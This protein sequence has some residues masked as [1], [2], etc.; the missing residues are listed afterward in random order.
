M[1]DI[2]ARSAANALHQCDADWTLVLQTSGAE[3]GIVSVKDPGNYGHN[4]LQN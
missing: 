1:F 4:F 3:M 2:E